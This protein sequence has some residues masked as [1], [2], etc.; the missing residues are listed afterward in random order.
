[1]VYK[2]MVDCGVR[3][4]GGIGRRLDGGVMEETVKWT[5]RWREYQGEGGNIRDE[6][7]LENQDDTSKLMT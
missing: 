1:M 2:L 3:I 4:D 7:R 5:L 6:H